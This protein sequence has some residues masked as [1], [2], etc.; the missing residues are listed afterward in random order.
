MLLCRLVSAGNYKRIVIAARKTA[1][2][3]IK[4]KLIVLR[5]V[6]RLKA[7]GRIKVLIKQQ[8]YF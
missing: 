4:L 7:V 1:D 3:K 6:C 5:A 2:A 8:I